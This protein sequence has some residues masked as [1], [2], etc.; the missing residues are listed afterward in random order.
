MVGC[1]VY[2]ADLFLAWLIVRPGDDERFSE[3]E[4]GQIDVHWKSL[5]EGGVFV[6]EIKN[7]S[8]FLKLTIQF[9]L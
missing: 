3:W 2:A 1:E 5:A 4:A 6:K 8:S 7:S 9:T